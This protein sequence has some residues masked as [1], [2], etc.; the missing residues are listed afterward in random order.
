MNNQETQNA[1]TFDEMI[2]ELKTI[3]DEN[4]LFHAMVIVRASLRGEPVGADDLYTA[5]SFL[6][7]RVM[8]LDFEIASQ[9]R[10]L[11][12]N[13]TKIARLKDQ[14]DSLGIRLVNLRQAL[15]TV[16]RFGNGWLAVEALAKDD[17]AA[18]GP[19]CTE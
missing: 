6:V 9:E 1:Q 8:S 15:C 12:E 17:E 7:D 18:I 3:E 16:I 10:M 4:S 19:V 14:V 11:S 5:Q 13:S 2:K